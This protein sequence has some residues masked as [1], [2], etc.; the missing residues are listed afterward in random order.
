MKTVIAAL[1]SKYIHSALAPW[2]L[3]S[4]CDKDCGEIVIK[5]YT[6]NDNPDGIL[7]SIYAEKA[8]VVAFSCY[9]WNISLVLRLCSDLKKVA[10]AA[11]I[12]LG[13]P[14][15]SYDADVLLRENP[16]VDAVI[17]GEGEIPF[18]LLLKALQSGCSTSPEKNFRNIPGLVFRSPSG[19]DIFSSVI[20]E[21]YFPRDSLDMLPSPYSDE[22]LDSLGDR[23]LYYESSRGCPY[24]CSYCL[25]STTKGV[26]Y[27][28][29][30][31]VKKDL[32]KFYKR[33]ARQ[34]KFVDRTFNCNR[35]RAKELFRYII[36][37][38]GPG[39]NFHFEAAAD[40][41]DDEMIGILSGAE[42]GLIQFEIGIQ[43]FNGNTLEAV[44]RKS[45]TD[46]LYKNISKLISA[47]NIHV[48][49]DLI[50][51]LPYEDF[52]TFKKSFDKTY[53]LFP[54]QLQLGFL[55]LLKGSLIRR[56]KERYKYKYREYPPYEVLSNAFISYDELTILKGIENLVEKYHNS[57]RFSETIKYLAKDGPFEF[58]LSFHKYCRENGLL[59]RPVAMR[60]LYGI[61]LG[62]V[63]SKMP[64]KETG[65]VRELM[66]LD[67]LAS[68]NSGQLP[69]VLKDEL[70]VDYKK[71][72]H[73]FLQDEGNIL[74]YL[75]GY[76][77]MPVSAIIRKIH[78]EPFN[79]NVTCNGEGYP[80]YISG[81]YEP[82]PEP[83]C[84]P[85][86][87]TVRGSVH[88]SARGSGQDS[89]KIYILFDYSERNPVTGRYRYCLIPDFPQTE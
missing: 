74:K 44:H 85:V 36:D 8:D 81:R 80:G 18:S 75:S 89:G 7:A 70:P 6:I 33:G 77:G 15:V 83:V 62:F 28:S 52:R 4:C 65:F 73:R 20:D 53:S 24:S 27:L 68:D 51:G 2:C 71:R 38:F 45:D 56:E 84:N 55:K 42:P 49:L 46:L 3:K 69:G 35:E 11:F 5:E 30:D 61:L 19:G 47:G 63:G 82:V 25:S 72:L 37:S 59:E 16:S 57:G 9:I 64:A 21:P 86:Y 78:V 41:F 48:H 87:D 54:H 50:A 60:E 13:G 32:E 67:F 12:V 31:R 17:C 79:F 58:F 29:L 34:V 23:I 40:H 88:G 66:K 26:R 39:I 1:N 43:S 14:E 10:P 76:Y 22:M